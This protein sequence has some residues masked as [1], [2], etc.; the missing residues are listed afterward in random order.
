M[1]CVTWQRHKTSWRE[2]CTCV[3]GHSCMWWKQIHYTVAPTHH[4]RRAGGL[5]GSLFYSALTSEISISLQHNIW[6]WND[7]RKRLWS[8][9]KSQWNPPVCAIPS[10]PTA[11][12]DGGVVLLCHN[13]TKYYST[14]LHMYSRVLHPPW[15]NIHSVFLL[16]W[17]FNYLIKQGGLFK[18]KHFVNSENWFYLFILHSVKDSWTATHAHTT[19]L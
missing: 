15:K 12:I 13:L 14:P 6:Q 17:Q 11:P 1:P 4:R 5:Q 2:L 3:T 10:S 16:I 7:K 9:D 18:R 8:Q 19:S